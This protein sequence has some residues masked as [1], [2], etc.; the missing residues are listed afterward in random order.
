H[1]VTGVK[2]NAMVSVPSDATV[3]GAVPSQNMASTIRTR[4]LSCGGGLMCP[5]T[6]RTSDKI[7]NRCWQA[8]YWLTDRGGTG[9]WSAP[10]DR[11]VAILWYQPGWRFDS[12]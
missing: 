2:C 8:Y 1:R 5:S 10:W 3:A 11:A 6:G 7:D 12:P 9:R 4:Q